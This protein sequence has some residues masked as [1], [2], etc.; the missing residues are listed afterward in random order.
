MENIE[1]YD[2]NLVLLTNLYKSY[3]IEDN[4]TSMNLLYHYIY[5]RAGLYYGK[6]KINNKELFKFIIEELNVD[7]FQN[8]LIYEE[9][10]YN[11]NEVLESFLENL[12][13]R[14]NLEGKINLKEVQDKIYAEGYKKAVK[15]K[16]SKHYKKHIQYNRLLSL[17]KYFNI[18]PGI[19]NDI[20]FS[21]K[22]NHNPYKRTLE[23]QLKSLFDSEKFISNSTQYIDEKTLEDYLMNNLE[24]IEKG[25]IYQGR[26]INVPGGKLDILAKDKDN[27][28]V[29]IE[30]K[31]DDDKSL[32]WQALHYPEEISKAYKV[33][34]NSIRMLT[35]A[36]SYKESILKRL[37]EIENVEMYNYDIKV[38]LGEIQ[39]LKI[40][41]M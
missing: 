26:Q 1:A 40:N 39:N 4:G 19:Y 21:T 24:L 32:I 41:K 14:A 37:K 18:I 36:P 30:L 22:S 38:S 25:L 35:I 29:I 23:E 33:N 16:K 28:L 31:I 3:G 12:E 15:F 20:N 5:I 27:N 13:F 9:I 8:N 2:L 34:K 17:N 7:V 6:K 10:E 11:V